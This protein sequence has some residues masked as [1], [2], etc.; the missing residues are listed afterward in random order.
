[1]ADDGLDW[2]LSLDV[3]Q[4][5]ALAFLKTIDKMT[6]SLKATKTETDKVEEASA[7]ASKGHKKH[8]ESVHGLAG[9]IKHLTKSVLEPF[10]ER[11][12]RIAEFEFIRKGVD[13]LIEAPMEALEKLKEIGEEIVMSAAKAERTEKA[14]GLMFGHEGAEEMLGYINKIRTSTEFTAEQ[15]EGAVANLGKVGFKGKGLTRALSAAQDLA[16]LNPDK[17]GGFSEAVMGL[18]QAKRT[19]MVNN[20]TL[21]PLGIGEN[22]FLKELSKRTGKDLG[23]LKKQLA[24]GKIDTEESLETL[25]MMITKKT[26]KLLG[27]AGVEMSGTLGARLEHVGE[28]PELFYKRLATSPGLDILKDTLANV[29][30]IFDPSSERGERIFEALDTAFTMVAKAASEIDV[31]SI[32]NTIED[33][34]VPAAEAFLG[35]LKDMQDVVSPLVEGFKFIAGAVDKINPFSDASAGK[36]AEAWVRNPGL[37]AANENLRAQIRAQRLQDKM[38]LPRNVYEGPLEQSGIDRL[39]AKQKEYGAKMGAAAVE[40]AKGPQGVDAHSPSKKFEYL[41]RMTGEGFARGIE[42]SAAGVD[43]AIGSMF[44]STRMSGSA[45][46]K[47]Q[48]GDVTVQVTVSGGSSSTAEQIGEATAR[49]VESI[50]PGALQ[51]ALSAIAQQTGG[52][53]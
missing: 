40:G 44:G 31:E 15:L 36:D 26:G 21:R 28:I 46:S 12:K 27:G 29:I 7:H 38:G 41:G 11:L 30:E 45:G 16:A 32:A 35:I 14:F 1:V 48:I 25:Y 9:A 33:G 8:E 13:M 22:D 17:A 6:A 52:D 43:E 37:M 47:V 49:A 39:A 20:R 51:S 50:L 53:N 23:T 24:A 10:E 5:D 34:I 42:I 4:D 3:Q 19:G 2:L 18:D